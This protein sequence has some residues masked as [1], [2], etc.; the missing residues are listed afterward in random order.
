MNKKIEQ[1]SVK[2]MSVS[3]CLGVSEHTIHFWGAW[4]P[5]TTPRSTSVNV[6]IQSTIFK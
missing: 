1:I 6:C 5:R 2:K 3:V 4:A